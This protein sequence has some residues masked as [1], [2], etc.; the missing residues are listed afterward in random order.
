MKSSPVED[1]KAF[2]SK[3]PTELFLKIML[4][5]AYMKQNKMHI[6]SEQ[7]TL[8]STL[9]IKCKTNLP[10]ILPSHHSHSVS[11]CEVCLHKQE[12]GGNVKMNCL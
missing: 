2:K 4:L 5:L 1:Q 3:N 7:T 9:Y 6:I 10:L 8:A 11:R 12:R